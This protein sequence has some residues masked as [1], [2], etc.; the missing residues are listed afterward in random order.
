MRSFTRIVAILGTAL[1]A[2]AL[3]T[4][5][6]A[7]L[8]L[9]A[10]GTSNGFS[11][12]TF[13]DFSSVIGGGCCSGPFGVAVAGN[14]N[15]LVSAAGTRYVFSNTDGQTPGSAISTTGSGSGTVAY[16]RAGGLAYGGEGGSFVQFKNDG[17][18]DHVLTGVPGP[19]LGMWGAPNGHII[20][21]SGAGLIDID[22]LGAGGAGTFR[23]INGAFGDGVTVSTDG[24]TA[25]LEQS[26]GIQA[27]DIATGAAGIFISVPGGS[28]DGTGVIS[29]GALDGDLIIN[30]N[31]GDVDLYH[32]A[33]SSVI[34][35]A[36]GSSPFFFDRGDYVASDNLGCLFLDEGNHVD[37]LC[38]AGSTIGGGG[39][40]PEPTTA[41]LVGAALLGLGA[42]RRR[43]A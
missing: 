33:T 43:R 7:S 16:A 35:I 24:T 22:P 9:T 3:A 25:Y 31:N 4:P 29:G 1:A 17:T 12:T 13:A 6:Q 30:N 23:V 41:L 18:V 28:A 8:T 40:L 15:V 37:R 21:T 38:L 36:T 26:G 11:L 19:F 27:Y 42:A 2:L 10:A 39:T 34:T 32:F 14:G 20:A 5:A